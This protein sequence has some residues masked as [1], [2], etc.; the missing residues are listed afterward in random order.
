[1]EKSHGHSHGT[2]QDQTGG[3]K[4]ASEARLVELAKLMAA[5]MKGLAESA[6]SLKLLLVQDG[7][8]HSWHDAAKLLSGASSFS[9]LAK[10]VAG[11]AQLYRSVV[12]S[13]LQDAFSQSGGD[14]LATA[15]ESASAKFA[16][17]S[18]LADSVGRL[19]QQLEDNKRSSTQQDQSL[20]QAYVG[21]RN[22]LGTKLDDTENEAVKV[23][24]VCKEVLTSAKVGRLLWRQ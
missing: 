5:D 7:N 22:G 20:L 9:S 13:G 16:D 21:A 8:P 6:R 2:G 11:K 4:A 14:K 18:R 1:M 12:E 17:A 3:A 19:L 10:D 23:I 24:D 15:L